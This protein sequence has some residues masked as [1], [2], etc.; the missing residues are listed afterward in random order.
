MGALTHR[1]RS[2]GVGIRHNR[3]CGCRSNSNRYRSGVVDN[4]GVV[5]SGRTSRIRDEVTRNGKVQH[6]RCICRTPSAGKRLGI[7]NATGR[8]DILA[9]GVKIR[10]VALRGYAGEKIDRLITGERAKDVVG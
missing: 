4:G 2:A 8:V 1:T 10:V 5:A 3:Q 9:A 6:Q 7:L